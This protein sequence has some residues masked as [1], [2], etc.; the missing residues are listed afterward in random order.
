VP[1]EERVTRDYRW[2]P[3]RFRE[4]G[5]RTLFMLGG[6][7]PEPF[8]LASEAVAGALPNCEVVVMPGQGHAA[9][10]TGT[11]LFLRELLA[12]LDGA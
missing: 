10:D 2:E 7:S 6:D 5:V 8:R 1:R 9:M 11:E 3:D 12:F 4:L